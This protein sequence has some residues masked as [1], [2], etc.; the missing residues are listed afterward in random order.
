MKKLLL[1]V[2][3]LTMG[4]AMGIEAPVTVTTLTGGQVQIT[5]EE[6]RRA[7]VES[8]KITNLTHAK[9]FV[10]NDDGSVTISQPWFEFNGQPLPYWGGRSDPNTDLLAK[11]QIGICRHYGF[12]SYI[13]STPTI[14]ATSD[15]LMTILDENGKLVE[16]IAHS[17]D[18]DI[19]TITCR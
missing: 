8:L 18:E 7:Y 12:G 17:N 2:C 9:K 13:E 1:L 15:D 10:T 16:T 4:A 3:A 5:P 11:N 6:A 14:A 19:D